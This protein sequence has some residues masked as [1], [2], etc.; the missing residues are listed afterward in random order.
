MVE[1]NKNIQSEKGK[2]VK[3]KRKG[4]I[5]EVELKVH[6]LTGEVKKAPRFWCP[7]C[8]KGY[9]SANGFKY[10]LENGHGPKKTYTCEVCDKVYGSKQGLNVH[11]RQHSKTS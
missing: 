9:S 5:S 6:H 10:H 2:R 1:P 3:S 8:D 7:T 4:L 11:F